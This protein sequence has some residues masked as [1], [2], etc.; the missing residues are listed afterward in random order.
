MTDDNAY[1]VQITFLRK[2]SQDLTDSLSK[3]LLWR[4]IAQNAFDVTPY[5]NA[6]TILSGVPEAFEIDC[7]P[8]VVIDP[9]LFQAGWD[10][11][12]LVL[13]VTCRET[14]GL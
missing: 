3:E 5:A 7:D 14:R 2:N 9:V 12:A 11:Q 6:P 1:Q 4:Q 13:R 8:S 10:V